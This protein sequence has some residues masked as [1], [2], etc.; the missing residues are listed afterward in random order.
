[1][2]ASLVVWGSGCGRAS[3]STTH[4]TD[5][6]IITDMAGVQ[7]AVPTRIGRIADAWRA[8]NEVLTMLG[9]GVKI[10]ATSIPKNACPWLYRVNP[11]LN[12]AAVCFGTD[13]NLEE[14]I[15]AK[16]DIV[17][18]SVGAQSADAITAAGMPVVQLNLTDFDTL[19][20]CYRLTGEILG[21]AAA[22][23][24]AKYVDYLDSRIE[25][26]R[27]VTSRLPDA[28]R[29][30]V[31]HIASVDPI[32]V[33]GSDTIIDRWITLAGG[34]NAARSVSGNFRPVT[35]EQIL[36]WNPDVVIFMSSAAGSD[37]LYTEDKWK[38][39][40]AIKTG[41]LVRNPEGAFPWDRYSAEEALQ[42]QWAAKTLHPELFPTLDLSQ[43]TTSFYAT[44]MNYAL[45]ADDVQRILDG[46]P[47]VK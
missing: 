28:D 22:E 4:S 31:L 26:I 16:P 36:E 41:R 20:A 19:K 5:R 1:L 33:D 23:R 24:A 32:Q 11:R 10:V 44:F 37:G 9:E 8:H 25:S 13:V 6:R 30:S 34:R 15:R 3:D 46:R 7:V 40:P 27:S 38:E 42:I 29:P 43:E 35:I 17:F 45:S 18:A 14:L 2:L 47:P 12:S 39:V 21:K